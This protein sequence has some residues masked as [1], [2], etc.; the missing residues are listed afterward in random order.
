LPEAT[1]T[2]FTERP[3]EEGRALGQSEGRVQDTVDDG[4]EGWIV[5]P[6]GAAAPLAA[7]SRL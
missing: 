5:R 3:E 4:H 7:R 1:A 6:E 2:V